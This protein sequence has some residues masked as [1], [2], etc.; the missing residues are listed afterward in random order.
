MKPTALCPVF[1]IALS[2]PSQFEQTRVLIAYSLWIGHFDITREDNA[3][4]HRTFS[5]LRR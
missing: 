3:N 4:D 1:G 2:I 5:K